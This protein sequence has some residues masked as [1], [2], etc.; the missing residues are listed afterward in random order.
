VIKL[1][2][3]RVQACLNIPQAFPVRKLGIGKTEELII[4][5]KPSDPVVALVLFNE[6]VKLISW[7]MLQY[8]CEDL[9]LWLM[10]C[11]FEFQRVKGYLDIIMEK[12]F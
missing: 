10:F 4:T 1:L 9:S 12:P 6:F 3:M 11:C 8:L 5:G 7:Q 2:V